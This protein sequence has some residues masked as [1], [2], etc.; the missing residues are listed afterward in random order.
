MR[1]FLLSSCVALCLVGFASSAG[2]IDLS[3]LARQNTIT[4]A[5]CF[6]KCL[7]AEQQDQCRIGDAVICKSQ[8]QEMPSVP[9]YYNGALVPA[10]YEIGRNQ[11][12]VRL[13]QPSEVACQMCEDDNAGSFTNQTND[14][15]CAVSVPDTGSNICSAVL[16]LA[17]SS[18]IVQPVNLSRYREFNTLPFNEFLL[19]CRDTQF[20]PPGGQSTFYASYPKCQSSSDVNLGPLFGGNGLGCYETRPTLWTTQGCPVAAGCC[21]N[22]DMGCYKADN[23]DPKDNFITGDGKY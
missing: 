5:E 13:I 6:A 10:Q 23:T 15:A 7:R 11:N 3:R 9:V 8:C 16:G 17:A 22:N 19:P 4:N 2:A 12:I 1:N 21:S 20:T 18:A 14:V